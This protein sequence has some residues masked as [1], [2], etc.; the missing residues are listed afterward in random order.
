MKGCRSV[1]VGNQ[2]LACVILHAAVGNKSSS[3]QT[4]CFKLVMFNPLLGFLQGLKEGET[5]IGRGSFE[6]SARAQLMCSRRQALIQFS[7]TSLRL[8][9]HGCNPL[10]FVICH[11]KGFYATQVYILLSS[12]GINCTH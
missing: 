6:A 9:C 2:L 12:T 1:F 3:Q 7:E 10:Y 4:C 11:S 5:W 8:E